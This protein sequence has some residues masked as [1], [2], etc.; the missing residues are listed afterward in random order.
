MQWAI[1]E[2]D[3]E[4]THEDELSFRKGD[5]ILVRDCDGY[6][7]VFPANRCRLLPV[8]ENTL[9]VSADN[10][11]EHQQQS[12]NAHPVQ[13]QGLD[14]SGHQHN[15]TTNQA[16]EMDGTQY[17]ESQNIS[18][19]QHHSTHTD[20]SQTHSPPSVPLK[21]HS[22][23]EQQWD[24]IALPPNWRVAT[25]SEGKPYYYNELTEETSWELPNA[26]S[27]ETKTPP[28]EHGHELSTEDEMDNNTDHHRHNNTVN[29]GD[30]SQYNIE[31][32]SIDPIYYVDEDPLPKGWSSAQDKNGSRY[33]F[34]EST[35]ETTWDRPTSPGALRD[36]VQS[37]IL[38]GSLSDIPPRLPKRQPSVEDNMLQGQLLGMSLSE[39]ELRALD[40]NQLPPENIQRKGALRVK[41][42]RISTNSTIT[43]WKDYWVVIYRGFLLFYRDDGGVIKNAHSMK[44]SV[45]SMTKI[46]QVTQVKLSGCFDADK[47]AVEIPVNGQALTKKKNFFYITPG[48]NV[49]LLLQDASG[50]SEKAWVKDIGISLAGRKIDEVSGFEESDLIQILKRQTAASGEMSGLKMNKKIEDN[51]SKTNKPP[52]KADKAR[53]IRNMVA[54]GIHVP[55]RR[56]TQDDKIKLTTEGDHG[57]RDESPHGHDHAAEQPTAA[58]T[59]RPFG[60]LKQRSNRELN[61]ESTSKKDQE[62]GAHDH[63]SGELVDSGSGGTSGSLHHGAKAK[64]S[65]MSRNFFS[66]DKDKDKANDK[67]KA[68]E[69]VKERIWDKKNYK[70]KEKVPKKEQATLKTSSQ[71][72]TGV[73]GGYLEVELGRSIPRV[74]ELCVQAI[75]ARG[76]TTAGIY[77][78]SGHMS[79]I[80]NLKRG[81]ND[82]VDVESMVEDEPD[83]NTIAALLKLYFRELR[84]PLMLFEFYSD[85]IAAADISDYNE[86]LYTIKS[87]VHS[88]PES[89]F[90]TLQYL[91]MHL[92]RVQDEYATTK[93]DSANLAIC[94][95]PNLLR[96]Q[97]DDLSSIIN[98]GKQSSIIDTLIEQREWVFDPYPEDDDDDEYQVDADIEVGATTGTDGRTTG[99]GHE[100]G[101]QEQDVIDVGSPEDLVRQVKNYPFESSLDNQHAIVD[102]ELLHHEHHYL[103]PFHS[104]HQGHSQESSP[105][106]SPFS[107]PIGGTSPDPSQEQQLRQGDRNDSL[108]PR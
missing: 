57:S 40:L 19:H 27:S 51:D 97:V 13:T 84:E 69:R 12:D 25:N 2:W 104:S 42:Q 100:D 18:Q 77:R 10:K 56:S 52:L 30:P 99:T 85:F 33:F 55:R 21:E 78:V 44:S 49:R 39:E 76:L 87:L 28:V 6:T 16:H 91:M 22:D 24:H 38:S 9:C 48:A 35:G 46:K 67:E 105:K 37:P 61:K 11:I 5:H 65:N 93:M 31:V 7:G 41:S 82:N 92:G 66:K 36:I 50:G 29:N 101:E 90:S 53:G 75:E 72:G 96:Q 95:A 15:H 14:A 70:H 26:D 71:D 47:I 80:Q 1:A 4:A 68:K 34:N 73:F 98:T 20:G 89:N 8:V 108:G 17:H 79:S 107:P 88:L 23:H 74:V 63:S 32:L 54:H 45:E 3:Y 83:V 102:H 106:V 103:N 43:S 64:L 58:S 86:K 94:F 60:N 62:S 59:N 81:F